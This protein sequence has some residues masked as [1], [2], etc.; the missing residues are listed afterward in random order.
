ML[1]IHDL[2][3]SYGTGDV[4]HGISMSLPE[5]RVCCLL[6][7]NGAG[8]ST[9]MRALCGLMRPIR[10][11]VLFEGE[12]LSRL[13]TDAIVSRGIVLVPEGR[14][15]FSPLTVRENLEMGAYLYLRTRQYT[16]YKRNLDRVLALFP[17]LVER[18]QQAAGTLSGGEQQMLAIGRALMSGPRLLMLDEP[19]MGLA[20]LV[21]RDI[22]SALE[23]L[24]DEGL[25]LLIAEQNARM[26]LAH[27]D[28][29]YVLQ[30]GAIAYADEATALRGNANVQAAYLGV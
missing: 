1:E 17:K 14:R 6:G 26:T 4:L 24:R 25:T 21:V 19:T 23:T 28:F 9:T 29:G 2:H 22:F 10:G 8:K 7:S 5:R 13:S 16:Q 11:R 12:D 18:S 30:E 27:S 3:A 20:P 15:V